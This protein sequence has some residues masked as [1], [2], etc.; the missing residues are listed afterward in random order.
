MGVLMIFHMINFKGGTLMSGKQSVLVGDSIVQE[1]LIFFSDEEI[2]A[3]N[4]TDESNDKIQ[5]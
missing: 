4:Q 1:P 5:Y 3:F 2:D